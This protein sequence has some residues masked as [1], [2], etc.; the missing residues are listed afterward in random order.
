MSGFDVLR[1]E[2]LDDFRRATELYRTAR[3]H[4]VTVRKTVDC[5]IASVCIRESIPILHADRDF[6][7][8]ARCTELAVVPVGS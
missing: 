4:G 5:L 7:S 8:L 6:D 1:L 3:G 2:S